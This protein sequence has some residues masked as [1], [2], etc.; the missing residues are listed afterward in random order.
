VLDSLELVRD[1]Q[2][3]EW[4][5]YCPRATK[6]SLVCFSTDKGLQFDWKREEVGY[7]SS[8]WSRQRSRISRLR[9]DRLQS[10]RNKTRQELQEARDI[11]NPS[12]LENRQAEVPHPSQ[13][14]QP[15]PCRRGT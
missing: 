9:E 10:Q 8:L 15:S 3:E 12:M 2:N 1:S 13:L 6:V 7:P 11:Q 14:Y 5:L 4:P